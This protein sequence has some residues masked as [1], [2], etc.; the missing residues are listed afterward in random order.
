MMTYTLDELSK[1]W[2]DV[3][4]DSIDYEDSVGRFLAQMKDLSSARACVVAMDVYH[5]LSV[6]ED[7]KS[8]GLLAWVNHLAGGPVD[9]YVRNWTD[10]I[11][12]AE[13][14]KVLVGEFL[15][16][17]NQY[18]PATAVATAWGV[19]AALYTE[20]PDVAAAVRSWGRRRWKLVYEP[21][22]PTDTTLTNII[23]FRPNR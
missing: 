21:I 17:M 3:L 5:L 16:T 12:D 8:G 13:D 19:L 9:L 18:P 20:D 22:G 2:A 11:M 14:L 6:D 7:G 23:D 15:D 10:R 1:K 4:A